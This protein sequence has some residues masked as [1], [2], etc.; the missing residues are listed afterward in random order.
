MGRWGSLGE[1]PDFGEGKNSVLDMLSLSFLHIQA[2][3]ALGIKYMINEIQKG[4]KVSIHSTNSYGTPST[5]T[6]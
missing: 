5:S 2:P 1:E 6:M 3:R 4:T